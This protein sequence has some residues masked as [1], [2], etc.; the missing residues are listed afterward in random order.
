MYTLYNC[1]KLLLLLRSNTTYNERVKTESYTESHTMKYRHYWYFHKHKKLVSYFYGNWIHGWN[2][3]CSSKINSTN[4]R[5]LRWN[6]Y[7][8]TN[9]QLVSAIATKSHHQEI[10]QD[11][12][13]NLEQRVARVNQRSY[14]SEWR[15]QD[16]CQFL[17]C[18]FNIFFNKN[19]RKNFISTDRN[20]MCVWTTNKQKLTALGSIQ[21][22]R[23]PH[24]PGLPL[25]Q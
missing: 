12:V 10:A 8:L 11:L 3:N 1:T 6:Y 24:L 18:I 13:D 17:C 15:C 9:W 25:P 4:Y 2:W 19:W 14:N 16:L 7:K 5:S 21:V 23:L 22:C 20:T